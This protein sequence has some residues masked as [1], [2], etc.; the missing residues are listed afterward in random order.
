MGCVNINKLAEQRIISHAQLVHC[1]I[2]IHRSFYSKACGAISS[3][4]VLQQSL[5]SCGKIYSS[6]DGSVSSGSRCKTKAEGY[7]HFCLLHKSEILFRYFS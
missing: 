6:K 1:I 7:F 3:S 5:L 2:K 4:M